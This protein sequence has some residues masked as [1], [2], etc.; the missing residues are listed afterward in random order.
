MSAP[1]EIF[2]VLPTGQRVYRKVTYDEFLNGGWVTQGWAAS[3]S[4]ADEINEEAYRNYDAKEFSKLVS[5][6]STETLRDYMVPITIIKQLPNGKW[7]SR[8]V[9]KGEFLTKG[10]QQNGWIQRAT[11]MRPWGRR[12]QYGRKKVLDDLRKQRWWRPRRSDAYLEGLFDYY[13]RPGLPYMDRNL[14]KNPEY[15]LNPRWVTYNRRFANYAH[16]HPTWEPFL[17]L[18][19]LTDDEKEEYW[20]ILRTHF[21]R[22]KKTKLPPQIIP[23]SKLGSATRKHTKTRRWWQ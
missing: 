22:D 20:R 5:G 8:R 9:F 6:K 19:N 23:Y 4:H 7:A 21:E 16:K 15:T 3:D 13:G 2:K 10:W 18:P 17:A 12:A 11:Q 1:L 14:L